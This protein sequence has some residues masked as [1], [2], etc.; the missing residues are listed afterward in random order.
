MQHT[1][2]ENK[3]NTIKSKIDNA[4]KIAIFG[5]D[6]P[7]GDAIGSMLGLGRILEKQ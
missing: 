5:H 6:N 7:D 3:M 4:Q 1:D 2:Q